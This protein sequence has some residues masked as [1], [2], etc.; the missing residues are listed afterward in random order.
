MAGELALRDFITTAQSAFTWWRQCEAITIAVVQGHAIG[1]GFQLALACDL[2]AV[3]P[4]ASFAMREARLGLIPD[5]GGT[6][7]LVRAVGYPRALEI[8]ATGRAI[9]AAEAVTLGIAQYLLN[10]KKPDEQL[11]EIISEL[12]A[13]SRGVL[14]GLKKLL[15]VGEDSN[16]S[17][18]L[19][20]EREAQILRIAALL[21][22]AT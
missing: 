4:D 15:R 20:N 9:E 2:V 22:E 11:R 10:S 8:C 6:H 7:S 16:P 1:A 17:E 13:S 12:T 21:R 18:Q 3:M 19:D 14:S 5:L